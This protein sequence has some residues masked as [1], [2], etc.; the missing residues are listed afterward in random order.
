MIEDSRNFENDFL[1]IAI[2]SWNAKRR[3]TFD[4]F[5]THLIPKNLNIE[6]LKR[7]EIFLEKVELCAFFTDFWKNAK[8]T[9]CNCNFVIHL[10]WSAFVHA[11]EIHE[12]NPSQNLFWHCS[13]NCCAF[14][15][16]ASKLHNFDFEPVPVTFH[17]RTIELALL[18]FKLAKF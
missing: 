17:S 14:P 9:L 3:C 12:M 16:M 1:K 11:D 13:V 8:T 15:L 6:E 7:F 4:P 18:N 10:R 5:S 2:F